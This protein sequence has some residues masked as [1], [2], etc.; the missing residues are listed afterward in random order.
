MLGILE[1]CFK[2]KIQENHRFGRAIVAT[3]DIAP[4]EIIFKFGG[5]LITLKEF[6]D[7][8]EWNYA[9]PLQIGEDTYID[10]I[11]PYV[12]IN[13]SCSPNAGVR[14]NGILF[15]LGQIN[16]GEE[17]TFDYSTTV[18]DV[19]WSMEC[20]CH[21]PNCR[22]QIGDFMSIPHMQKQFYLE[23]NALTNYIK[24]LYY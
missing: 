22:G 7:K 12:L 17:I 11:E 9:N 8:Y 14:N 23:K 2:F 21:S 5:P 16:A 4:N 15:A 20:D 13:H 10:L 1:H 24:N 3:D 18:D 6:F 19:T